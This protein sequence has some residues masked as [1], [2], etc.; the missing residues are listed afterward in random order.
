MNFGSDKFLTPATKHKKKRE[1][2]RKWERKREGE[3]RRGGGNWLHSLL[4][5]TALAIWWAQMFRNTQM[6]CQEFSEM[7]W[8][9]CSII[10]TSL[11]K[12][13]TCTMKCVPDQPACN[14]GRKLKRVV[15]SYLSS[16]DMLKRFWWIPGCTC[17]AVSPGANRGLLLFL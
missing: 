12:E 2:E 7:F 5:C 10:S 15:T 4:A 16:E 6:F 17:L 1:W 9:D 13:S 3:R 8:L 11:P 14:R